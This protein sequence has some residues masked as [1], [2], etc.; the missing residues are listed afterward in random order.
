[1]TSSLPKSKQIIGV[2]FQTLFLLFSYFLMFLNIQIHLIILKAYDQ[3]LSL[4]PQKSLHITFNT[5]HILVFHFLALKPFCFHS[6]RFLLYH[7]CWINYIYIMIRQTMTLILNDD[8]TGCHIFMV[9]A[10]YRAI[11]TVL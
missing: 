7:L 4:T 3:Q 2:H 8:S 1:M 10:A 6:V 5:L 9:A 11:Y